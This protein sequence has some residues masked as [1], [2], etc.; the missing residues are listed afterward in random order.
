MGLLERKSAS[1]EARLS[2]LEDELDYWKK[3]S[4]PNASFEKNH[5]QIGRI[6]EVLKGALNE[7]LKATGQREREEGVLTVH[8]LWDFFR[9]KLALRCEPLFE[10]YLR[11]ADDFAWACYEPLR[12]LLP[13]GERR[14]PP[15]VFLNGGWS[16]YTAARG[17][18]FRVEK[19]A[20]QWLVKYPFQDAVEKLPV[21][22]IGV[23]WY[24]V[25]H[26]PDGLVIAHEMGHVIETELGFGGAIEQAVYA[27][28]IN[29]ARGDTWLGWKA[30][31]FADVFGCV[32]AGAAFARSL[33]DFLATEV[34]AP[35]GGDTPEGD[36][37]PPATLRV[38]LLARTLCRIGFETDGKSL[39][40]DWKEAFPSLSIAPE[41][42]KDAEA[43]VDSLL[44]QTYRVGEHNETLTNLL[45][46]SKQE[47]VAAVAT[48]IKNESKTYFADRNLHRREVWASARLLFEEDEK[49][50]RDS[51][52]AD[53]VLAKIE[54]AREKGVRG[55][56][57]DEL[58]TLQPRDL[59][60]GVALATALFG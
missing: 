54:S 32:A 13:P 34:S 23:P 31:A 17:V 5:T 36:P 8:A 9:S 6:T 22:M 37:H 39:E 15:L 28:K 2:S 7:R 43:M 19:G 12:S 47:D 53:R 26:L 25:A 50:Y 46:P 57:D 45:P 14:E 11:A 18:S 35:G 27:A 10:R 3:L 56:T 52:L 51:N 40:S 58:K 41:L 1:V 29:P 30:E 60:A 24:Q 49:T 44:E 55:S 33:V 48:D 42:S 4:E 20:G 59:A 21:P 16:P 38:R